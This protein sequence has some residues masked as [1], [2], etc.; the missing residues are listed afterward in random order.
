VDIAAVVEEHSFSTNPSFSVDVYV[1][2]AL[3]KTM[4]SL[5]CMLPC[6]GQHH[7]RTLFVGGCKKKAKEMVFKSI[8]LR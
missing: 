1:K 7:V 2:P 3:S 8:S 6:S 4:E 5:V